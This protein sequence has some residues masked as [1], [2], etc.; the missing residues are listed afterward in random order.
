MITK[1]QIVPKGYW[2]FWMV[3]SLIGGIGGFV[4]SILSGHKV[5]VLIG[6]ICLLYSIAWS[7]YY[8]RIKY[9]K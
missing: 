7:V 9:A 2:T 8:W 4:S 1:P 5:D 6:V 3:V